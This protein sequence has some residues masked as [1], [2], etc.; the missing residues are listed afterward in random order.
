M[1]NMDEFNRVS[2]IVLGKLFEA[3]PQPIRVLV[4]DVNE[5]SD[6]KPDETLIRNFDATVT[7]LASEGFLKY[8]SE[9]DE[10]RFFNETVLT[11]R[12]LEILRSV[13]SVLE[14][15]E[16]MGQKFV[17]IMKGGTKEISKE[18]LKVVVNQLMSVGSG[19][20]GI[21]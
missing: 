14:E 7:F 3:F 20:L 17:E 4:E 5:N 11:L 18:V 15:K 8:G 10:G 2:V 16:S 6:T 1:S 12:G 13:P 21:G 9:S 19:Q